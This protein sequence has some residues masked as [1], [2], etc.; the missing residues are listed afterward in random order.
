MISAV[1]ERGEYY[2]PIK[3]LLA[4]GAPVLAGSDWP[5]AAVNIN[6]WP[7]IEAMVT[8]ADPSGDYPGKLWPEQA[9][10]L[11]QALEIYTLK[12]AQALLLG[13]ASG[14]VEVGKSADLIVLN[15][16]LFEVPITAVSDTQVEMTL[17]AG[18]RVYPR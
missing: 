11:A 4:S 13:S 15:H 9:I 1:G 5:A 16:N 6:P 8:R 2:W 3:S 18:K 17:F 12:G 7:S 10:T 14:S